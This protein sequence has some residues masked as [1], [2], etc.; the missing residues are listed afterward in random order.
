MPRKLDNL[1]DSYLVCAQC[2]YEDLHWS[3]KEAENIGG[4]KGAFF[5]G[6]KLEREEGWDRDLQQKVLICCPDCGFV[7]AED[8]V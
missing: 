7:D 6:P 2:G 3:E 1:G 5:I 4:T 8:V